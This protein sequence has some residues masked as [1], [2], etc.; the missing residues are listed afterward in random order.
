[1]TVKSDDAAE[2]LVQRVIAANLGQ[3]GNAK[4]HAKL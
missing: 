2:Q 4:P 1:V 3:A